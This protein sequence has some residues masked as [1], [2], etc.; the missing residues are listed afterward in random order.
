MFFPAVSFLAFLS[1]SCIGFFMAGR[2][3]GL[4]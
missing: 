4:W 1:G 2:A 3:H